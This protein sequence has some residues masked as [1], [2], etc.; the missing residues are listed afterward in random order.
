MP[1]QVIIQKTLTKTDRQTAQLF[2][3]DVFAKI[4]QTF[5]EFLDL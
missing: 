3:N 1:S 2:R 4:D 5:Q